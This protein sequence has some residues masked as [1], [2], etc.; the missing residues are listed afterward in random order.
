MLLEL[1]GH[2]S[3][4]PVQLANILPTLPREESVVTVLGWGNTHLLDEEGDRVA[5][6]VLQQV[7]LKTLSN[8]DCG[9]M[10][11]EEAE[12]ILDDSLCAIGAENK[13]SCHGD[14]GGPLIITNG[15]GFATDV[16]V[17]VVSWGPE[18]CGIEGRKSQILTR[19]ILC[20]C[21]HCLNTNPRSFS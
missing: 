4:P 16:Q 15:P 8:H 11:D 19:S 7:D 12:A 14:S 6:D 18:E 10:W 5:A 20:C 2:S 1:A 17:G 9:E 3:L 21:S 13:G